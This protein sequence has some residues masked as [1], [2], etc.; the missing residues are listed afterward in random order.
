MK[1]GLFVYRWLMF[2]CNIIAIAWVGYEAV[3]TVGLL[4]PSAVIGIVAFFTQKD[5]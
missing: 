5:D 3:G 4:L 2:I 1:T